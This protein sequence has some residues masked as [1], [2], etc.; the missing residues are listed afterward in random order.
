MNSIWFPNNRVCFP[1]NHNMSI[2]ITNV[3]AESK[4]GSSQ[5]N[6]LKKNSVYC[7]HLWRMSQWQIDE[8]LIMAF[9]FIH[10]INFV[11]CEKKS[12]MLFIDN[13]IMFNNA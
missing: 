6:F 8:L 3:I 10:L 12:K 9:A 11:C 7:S 1:E 5:K 2:I 13:E 4:V